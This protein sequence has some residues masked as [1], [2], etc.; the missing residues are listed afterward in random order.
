[1]PAF[2][3]CLPACCCQASWPAAAAA[4][5]G[6]EASLSHSLLPGFPQL[7]AFQA[8][9]LPPARL[10]GLST[11]CSRLR[12]QEAQVWNGELPCAAAAFSLFACHNSLPAA[13]FSGM[14]CLLL[15]ACLSLPAT[16]ARRI[17]QQCYGNKSVQYIKMHKV[18]ELCENRRMYLR[19]CAFNVYYI[20]AMRIHVTTQAKHMFVM[21]MPMAWLRRRTQ[22]VTASAAQRIKTR[23]HVRARAARG[24]PYVTA[25]CAL[26]TCVVTTC[27][28]ATLRRPRHMQRIHI[29]VAAR[30]GTYVRLTM[31][32]FKR[33]AMPWSFHSGY[34]CHG[35]MKC[36]LCAGCLFMRAARLAPC[37]FIDN[38]IAIRQMMMR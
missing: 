11:A 38:K 23:L 26:R 14:H 37:C 1:M 17:Q 25:R 7:P 15:P 24:M 8:F 21:V 29:H 13:A 16:H 3:A 36:L 27:H 33:F 12:P 31:M 10:Q 5:S 22:Y 19:P 6:Q 30:H 20:H 2:H 32:R 18:Q 9:L 35:L 28:G 4:F 34:T